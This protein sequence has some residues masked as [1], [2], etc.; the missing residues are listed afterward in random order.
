MKI[1]TAKEL[2]NRTVMKRRFSGKRLAAATENIFSALHFEE[3]GAE[4][5]LSLTTHA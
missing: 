5:C 2:K 3:C 1:V 4:F